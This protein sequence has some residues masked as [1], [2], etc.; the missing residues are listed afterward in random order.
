MR[1]IFINNVPTYLTVPQTATMLNHRADV[2]QVSYQNQ[3]ELLSVISY[4]EREA[5][6]LKSAYILGSSLEK[7]QADFIQFY[8]QITAAGGITFNANNEALLIYRHGKWD[9]P[10]GKVEKGE[11]IKDAAIREVEEET[12]ITHLHIEKEMFLLSNQSNIT[13]HT[14]FNQRRKRILKSTYWYLM[15][16]SQLQEGTPQQAEGITKVAWIPFNELPH[17]LD[18]SFGSIK[19]VLQAVIN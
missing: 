9:L 18:K 7:I 1:K 5:S 4:I 19:D 16:C 17:Y 8:K 15:Q 13:Y 6:K 2:L 10:K 3:R 11:T 14:Y 12:G